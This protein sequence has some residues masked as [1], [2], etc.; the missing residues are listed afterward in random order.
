MHALF[1]GKLKY[2]NIYVIQGNH[3]VWAALK[4]REAMLKL[5]LGI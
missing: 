3:D 1:W 5:L 4:I 2:S